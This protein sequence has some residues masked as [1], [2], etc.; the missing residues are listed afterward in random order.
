MRR[1]RRPPGKLGDTRIPIRS[2]LGA[3]RDF[4][5]PTRSIANLIEYKTNLMSQLQVRHQ[6]LCVAFVF[7]ES[8][9]HLH[10]FA[11]KNPTNGTGTPVTSV[12]FI[13]PAEDGSSWWP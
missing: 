7:N 3:A 1:A 9:D 5:L 13:R 6:K 4:S 2:S 12:S 11:E 8:E 10:K